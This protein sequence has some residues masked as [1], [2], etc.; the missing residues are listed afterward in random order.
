MQ[1]KLPFLLFLMLINEYLGFREIQIQRCSIFNNVYHG[2]TLY[3]IFCVFICYNNI[4][5]EYEF[6]N[7]FLQAFSDF[8]LFIDYY[9]ILIIK[10]KFKKYLRNASIQNNSINSL[11][12]QK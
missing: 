7:L 1:I 9:L 10:Q 2:L 4:F 8:S 12:N 6:M 11:L 5:I 3:Y